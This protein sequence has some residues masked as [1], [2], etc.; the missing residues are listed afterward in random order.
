[1]TADEVRAAM[2]E[3]CERLTACGK[4]TAAKWKREMDAIYRAFESLD[5]DDQGAVDLEPLVMMEP[6]RTPG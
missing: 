4:V 1:M 6:G 3:A 2:V 5:A